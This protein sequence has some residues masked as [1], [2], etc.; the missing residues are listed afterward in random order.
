MATQIEGL[1]VLGSSPPRSSD[2]FGSNTLGKDEFLKLLVAQLGAQDPLKPV[3]NQAFIAQL[4]QFSSVEQSAQTNQR[5]EQLL[6]AQAA[7]NQTS[8]ANLVGKDIVYRTDRLH[9]DGRS[10][11]A[12]DAKLASDAATVSA[13]ITDAN[14]RTVRTITINNVK[15]GPVH[16]PWNGMDDNGN[17]VAPGEYTVKLTA[18]DADGKAITVTSQS[19][20]RATGISFE[21]GYAELII[22]GTRVRMSDVVEI[23]QP[24]TQPETNTL[25]ST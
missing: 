25:T 19:S 4:A 16:L 15:A 20:A 18:G 13:I 21:A 9:C 22:D 2:A 1:G 7:N 5:L 17:T 6:M 3:D 10:S 12:V 23:N 14:G 8:A 24:A 11:T